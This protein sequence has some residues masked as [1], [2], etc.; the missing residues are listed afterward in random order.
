MKAL[1]TLV[2][3]AVCAAA[4][5]QPTPRVSAVLDRLQSYAAEYRDRLPSF[6]CNESITSRR[7]YD[8]K[9][10]EEVKIEAVLR[11]IRN[12]SDPE[13]F[14]DR[15]EFNLVNGRPP[16]GRFKV[17]YFVSRAFSNAIGFAGSRAQKACYDY[18]LEEEDGGSTLRLELAA[19]PKSGDP[20][21]K[22]VFEGYRK[23][24]VMDA[25]TGVIRHISRSMPEKTARKEHE[26]FSAE[27]DYGPVHFGDQIF[28]LP[29]RA[30]LHHWDGHGQMTATYSNCQRYTGELKIIPGQME[31]E[32]VGTQ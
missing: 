7:V 10:K 9:V 1:P 18:R 27:I 2:L 14:R 12:P 16:K 23:T 8:G 31:A 3:V 22:D 13:D 19:K 26:V 15:Y 28:W 32:P 24:V 17:P 6:S 30:E 29:V 4:C 20:V 11:E 21:C 5:S 25:A